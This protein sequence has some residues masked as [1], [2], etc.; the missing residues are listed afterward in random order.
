MN[1]NRSKHFRWNALTTV[2][3]CVIHPVTDTPQRKTVARVQF[4][5]ML[6][7]EKKLL[8]K[9]E[10]RYNL[11][12]VNEHMLF[13]G[14]YSPNLIPMEWHQAFSTSYDQKWCARVQV[15]SLQGDFFARAMK[16]K[17]GKR[18]SSVFVGCWFVWWFLIAAVNPY[19]P[20]ETCGITTSQATLNGLSNNHTHTH[21]EEKQE[22][23]V[24]VR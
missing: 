11:L 1:F 18:T 12:P 17:G 13:H 6:N 14:E 24:S 4:R 20:Q 8:H 15:L 2:T 10:S 21:I 22:F 7:R 23:S 19:R 3:R 5:V 9:L 16:T